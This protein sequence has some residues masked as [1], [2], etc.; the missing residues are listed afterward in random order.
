MNSFSQGVKQMGIILETLFC[1]SNDFGWN[2]LATTS[3]FNFHKLLYN[4]QGGLS[5][6]E[7]TV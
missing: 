7:T 2:R 4:C 1:E 5:Q 3:Y 6:I